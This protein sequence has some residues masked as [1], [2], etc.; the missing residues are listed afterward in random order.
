[1]VTRPWPSMVQT[2]WGDAAAFGLGAAFVFVSLLSRAGYV[3]INY[4]KVERDLLSLLDQYD[5]YMKI[6][7]WENL[8]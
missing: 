7:S 3:T 1:M 5:E 4:E 8:H 2:V 6:R